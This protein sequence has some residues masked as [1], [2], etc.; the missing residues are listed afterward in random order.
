MTRTFDSGAETTFDGLQFHMHAPS[1][2]TVDG[3]QYDMEMHFVHATSGGALAVLGVFFD[4][5]AGGN[6]EN[7]FLDQWLNTI[8]ASG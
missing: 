3:Q 8:P 1:E 4:T 2:N 5:V 7:L 6:A